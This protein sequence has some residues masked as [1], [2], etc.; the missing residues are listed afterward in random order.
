[1]RNLR[2]ELNTLPNL[3]P[4]AHESFGQRQDT[5]CLRG[6]ATRLFGQISRLNSVFFVSQVSREIRNKII[7]K[8]NH[9]TTLP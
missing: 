7:F 3:V 4:R 2:W 6:M 5:E 1:M 9:K 8:F